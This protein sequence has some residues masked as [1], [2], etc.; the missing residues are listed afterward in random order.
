MIRQTF[1]IVKQSLFRNKLIILAVLSLSLLLGLIPTIKSELEAGLVESAE[2]VNN[3][4][5]HADDSHINPLWD[6]LKTKI[7]RFD[8]KRENAEFSEK[9]TY[10]ILQG[11]NTL[12]SILIAY[13]VISVIFFY[14]NYLSERL[15]AIVKKD[16][17]H[18]LRGV[19][20]RKSLTVESS[21]II[22]DREN[23]AGHLSS[24]V[25]R[26]AETISSTYSFLL[27]GGQYI[28]SFLVA[29]FVVATKSWVLALVSVLVVIVQLLVSVWQARTLKN[30]REKFDEQ[31]NVLLGKTDDILSKREILLAYEQESRYAEKI[32]GYTRSHADLEKSLSTREAFFKG[33]VNLAEDYGRLFVLATALILAL[34]VDKEN[35]NGSGDV[36]FLIS[37][38][39]RMLVPATNLLNRYDS[40]RRS[41]SIAATYLKVLA[42]ENDYDI[43]GKR[44][45]SHWKKNQ[46]I[47]FKDMSFSYPSSS[48]HN[49]ILKGVSFT[50][51][52]GKTTL[53]LGPSG[54]GKTTLARILMGF[55]RKSSGKINIGGDEIDSFSG[56]ILRLQMS[57][58]AQGDHILDE[59]I[60]ENLSWAKGGEGISSEE[61]ITALKRVGLHDLDN[62]EE[63]LSKNSS[64]LSGGQQQ[65]LS[66]ARMMLDDAEIVIM[67]E[68]LAG[69]DIF[70]FK[71]LMPQLK[72]LL[73]EK[74]QT[75]LL[76][77]HRLLYSEMVDHVVIMDDNGS[78]IEEGD[79]QMLMSNQDGM[80]S[81]LVRATEFKGGNGH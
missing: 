66:V 24:A 19:G 81:Q 46:D 9:I 37:I 3:S 58:V 33:L 60:R 67:D 59:T 73:N 79:V 20:L 17:Y 50:I 75:V 8:R 43:N 53:L 2:Q 22:P 40:I 23:P 10:F 21:R 63:L 62:P 70:T 32:D 5:F 30:E 52:K 18:D 65:R 31:R 6:G 76:I 16:L 26:G 45:S 1:P 80:F 12:V 7:D 68:P 47:E 44:D 15:G 34:A 14:I 69:V 49:M 72:S 77:S 35:I 25:Q 4:V 51:P 36:Y 78:I 39:V 71:E 41:E 42:G 56:S 57:Y 48:S 11:V 55:C 27:E 54:C 61:M 64:V 74:Q 28:L 29:L 13:L 38:Y